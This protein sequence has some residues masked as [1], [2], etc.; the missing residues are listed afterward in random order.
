MAD[1]HAL[2]RKFHDTHVKLTQLDVAKVRKSRSQL[3]NRLRANAHSVGLPNRFTEI[4]QGSYKME[5]MIQRRRGTKLEFDLDVGVAFRYE[6]LLDKYG[7]ELEPWSVRTRVYEILRDDF[8]LAE[9]PELRRNCIC[10]SFKGGAKIDVPVYRKTVTFNGTSFLELASGDRWVLSDPQ[11]VCDWFSNDAYWLGPDAGNRSQYR[12]M[13]RMLKFIAWKHL[14]QEAPSGFLIT[15]LA[16]K[17]F[18]SG[19]EDSQKIRD[20]LALK[21]LIDRIPK[22]IPNNLRVPHPVLSGRT[23]EDRH[24]DRLRSFG[25]LLDRLG[26]ALKAPYRAGAKKDVGIRGWGDVLGVSQ[27]TL[28]KL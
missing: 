27:R 10:I 1:C 13:V 24:P 18:G 11:S 12:R 7:F 3:T 2:I 21:R 8:R 16:R 22:S 5:T 20:D 14:N 28:L 26:Q 17:C 15:V 19:G 23:I 9:D 6:D 4:L 25:E